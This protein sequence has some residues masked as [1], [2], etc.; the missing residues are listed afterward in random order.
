MQLG[1]LSQMIMLADSRDSAPHSYS[2][3]TATI[4]HPSIVIS[5]VN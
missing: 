4:V 3:V 1:K 2:A 5:I